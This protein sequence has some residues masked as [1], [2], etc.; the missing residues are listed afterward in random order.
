MRHLP[1]T[2]IA[3]LALVTGG[4]AQT[5]PDRR[6]PQ[7]VPERTKGARTSTNAEVLAFIDTLV[8]AGPA[9]PI[10]VERVGRSTEG[11][12]MPVLRVGV[13]REGVARPRV[14][15]MGNIHGGEVEGKEAVQMLLREIAQ[16]QHAELV[17][18]LEL[19][20][21]PVFN[22]DGN[23]AF[24]PLQRVNQNGPDEPVGMRPNAQR[25]D[26]NR[27]FIKTE[28]PEVRFLLGVFRDLDPH[29]FMDLHTTNGSEHGYHLTYA[30]S[31]ATNLAPAVADFAH[32]VYLPDV[33][34]QMRARHGLRAFDYGNFPRTR[35]GV[36]FGRYVTFG[37]EPRYATN[38]FGMRNRIAVLSEAYAYY[39]FERRI[40]F[41]RAF[42][43]ECLR[44]ASKHA[45]AL[46]RAC[47]VADREPFTAEMSFGFESRRKVVEEATILKGRNERQRIPGRG[48]RLRATG[49]AEALPA[50]LEVRFEA[51]KSEP[52]P[53][54]W[55]IRGA[56]D[57][58]RRRLLAHGLEVRTLA[59]GVE[60]EADRFIVEA[61]SKSPRPF[62]GHR[63]VRV[64]GAFERSVVTLDQGDLVVPRAQRMA[65]LAAQLLDPRSED[66]LLTWNF[67]DE[68]IVAGQALPVVRL[69]EL[70]E[71][72]SD[73]LDLEAFGAPLLAEVPSEE[74]LR[75]GREV[76]V[77]LV[78]AGRAVPTTAF[79]SEPRFEGREVRLG[80]AKEGV[81][82]VA[83]EAYLRG[84][85]DAFDGDGP[86]VV[87]PDAGVRDA[88]ILTVLRAARAA[89]WRTLRLA[90]PEGD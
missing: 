25:L 52:M 74:D 1:L 53:A 33:R 87:K 27:D 15:V 60:I 89:G 75:T 62:Q 26:L 3:A 61:A 58:V 37:H 40:A 59:G 85:A 57:A 21:L 10:T 8:Q 20:F 18:A 88:E 31:L 39:P 24:D 38:Y 48:T 81:L 7:T 50:K 72:L 17:E 44:A 6:W 28:S 4:L 82:L 12:S 77:L 68:A 32:D 19:W 79:E 71:G 11:R 13:R 14:L 69:P 65:R 35:S 2:I 16:G 78:A 49:E 34:G 9:V 51:G 55:A 30:T 45:D 80:V 73:P 66:G 36:D 70:P 90:R 41:T 64:R 83:S 76:R 29:V 23:D 22:P 84:L 42:V 5:S 54:G 43:I 47:D 67:F 56:S 63:L 46:M 86:L